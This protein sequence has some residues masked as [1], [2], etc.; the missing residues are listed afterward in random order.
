MQKIKLHNGHEIPV[1]GLG[2]WKSLDGTVG[3]AVEHALTKAGYTHID[4]AFIYRN[5]KEV[6][7]AFTASFKQG[8][9]REDIFITS[10]L[11]NTD[12]RPEQV[13]KACKKT[14]SDLQLDYLDLYLMHWGVA[15]PPGAL[16]PEDNIAKFDKVSI[17]ETWQAMEKLVEKGLVKSIGVANFTTMMLVDLLTNAKIMPAVNQIE[18]HP[19]N[20]QEDVIEFCQ[21]KN[22]AVTAYSPLGRQGADREGPRVFDEQL[23]QSLAKKYKKTEGQILLRWG[24][25][26]N[27]IVIPK[28][29]HLDRI[30]E[31]RDVFDFVLT[32]E[33]MKQIS[34]LN[35][36]YRFVDPI[37]WWGFPYFR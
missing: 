26:R 33:E 10:K 17:R 31:N 9:K 13:E 36:N 5:E 21:S 11:W 15:F 7:E 8:I 3:P 32:Q 23:I 19:Y 14:L 28:S 20:T 1:L 34:A 25:Q 37:G 4:C 16:E 18:L 2:T 30:D 27:T 35:K 6:G 12:H 24:I 29:V 22:I